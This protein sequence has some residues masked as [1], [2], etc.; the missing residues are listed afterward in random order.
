M[1]L[2]Q[3]ISS[4]KIAI[5]LIVSL[6]LGGITSCFAQILNVNDCKWMKLNGS[7]KSIRNTSYDAGNG[8][9]E[10]DFYITFNNKGNKIE[11]IVSSSGYPVHEYYYQ[12]DNYGKL[13]EIKNMENGIVVRNKRG[14]FFNKIIFKYDSTGKLVG[15]TKFDNDGNFREIIK[16]KWD[17]LGNNIETYSM[18]FDS[19]DRKR[20]YIYDT[21]NLVFEEKYYSEKG[22]IDE[23]TTYF[24]DNKGNRI[25][26]I[27]TS[28][29]TLRQ[30]KVICKYDINGNVIEELIYDHKK[31][32]K[33]ATCFEYK[34]DSH[35][36][37]IYKRRLIWDIKQNKIN[38]DESHRV[39]RKIKY[40]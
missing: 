6:Y 12:Y 22:N 39:I 2:H 36:N 37:W 32:L 9:F 16:Y 18:T 19:I 25:I 29:D 30:K 26:T 40:Y 1:E 17:S 11:E 15:N 3:L 13:S 5:L 27:S 14:K 8:H 31:N 28:P 4:K 35:N 34:Y 21:N 7:V 10:Y 24:Y 38:K 23:T 33:D 20:T